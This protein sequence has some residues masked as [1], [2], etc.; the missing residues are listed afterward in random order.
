MGQNLAVQTAISAA[1]SAVFLNTG[2]TG[3]L[4]VSL[5]NQ[6]HV[7]IAAS[8]TKAVLGA[9]G[10]LGDTLSTL[11]VTPATTSPGNILL[12]DGSS[13]TA[14]TLFV[15]GATS[16]ADLKPFVINVNSKATATTN[17]GWFITTGANVSVVAVGD[18]T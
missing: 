15:G 1:G 13:S 5:N 10:A 3:N 6:A 14:I 17:P 4:R 16:V 8:Q 18:F 11:I 12:Y 9:T 2:K 7:Q